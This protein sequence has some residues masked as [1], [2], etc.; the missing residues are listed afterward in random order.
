MK[1]VVF[2]FNAMV[3]SKLLFSVYLCTEVGQH[4]SLGVSSIEYCVESILVYIC[5][6]DECSVC[7]TSP[8]EKKFKS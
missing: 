4:E 2:K 5:P 6:K 8:N 1:M 3:I 7:Q